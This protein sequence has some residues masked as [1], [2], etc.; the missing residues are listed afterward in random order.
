LVSHQF[1]TNLICQ[2]FTYLGAHGWRIRHLPSSP[3]YF[4]KDNWKIKVNIQNIIAKQFFNIFYL[5]FSMVIGKK[6]LKE[7]KH[8]L[9]RKSSSCSYSEES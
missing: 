9:T 8:E 3:I 4:E 2:F 6:G 5:E 7:L 1:D